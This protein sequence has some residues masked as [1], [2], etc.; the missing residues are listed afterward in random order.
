MR[1]LAFAPILLALQIFGCSVCDDG[2]HQHFDSEAW[3]AL[4]WQ[5]HYTMCQDLL[6]SKVLEGTTLPQV[7]A[8]LGPPNG[9]SKQDRVS[10]L[11]RQRYILRVI[12]EVKVLDIRFDESGK[13]STAF[14]RGT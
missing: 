9:G 3:K 7:I 13:V 8:L 2:P 1:R 12:G 11:V 5:E 14:V 4:P 10:Y 6:E